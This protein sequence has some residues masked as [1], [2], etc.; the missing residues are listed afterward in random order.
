MRTTLKEANRLA[1]AV[2]I[3]GPPN[4]GKSRLLGFLNDALPGRAPGLSVYLVPGN[5]DGVGKYLT[6]APRLRS[7]LKPSIKGSWT[8]DTLETLIGSIRSCR[9]HLQLIVVDLGGKRSPENA[10]ILKACSHYIVVSREFQSAIS[11]AT[12]GIAGWRKECE[13]HDVEPLALIR[14]HIANHDVH[15]ATDATGVLVGTL[16]S[17]LPVEQNAQLV[18]PL[19][20]RLLAL[21]IPPRAIPPY[22]NLGKPHPWSFDKDLRTVGGMAT[23]IHEVALSG[24]PLSLGGLA[25]IWAYGLALHRALDV[26]GD[27]AVYAFDPKV[28]HPLIRIPQTLVASESPAPTLDLRARWIASPLGDGASLFV[29]LTRPDR[30]LP[31]GSEQ[32]L[33]R[34]PIPATAVPPVGPLVVSG[35]VP[36]WVH[37]AYSRWLR[38]QTNGERSIGIWDAGS[39]QA[40]L[41]CGPTSPGT[42]PWPASHAQ[43]QAE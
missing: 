34:L 11:E 2:A 23:R 3:V 33:A 42:L 14:S 39:E 19:L 15:A 37:L 8:P 27:I 43:P 24:R 32:D 5:P 13:A 40:V 1:P 16:R 20:D 9:R 7:E 12:D 28:E 21:E 26:A 31:P 18:E 4:S 35:R 36:I 38:L 25:P 41:L 22:I 10:A 29:D 17:D 30:L 6:H